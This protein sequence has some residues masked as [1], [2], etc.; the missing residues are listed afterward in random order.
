MSEEQDYCKAT[1]FI[2][3]DSNPLRCVK[4]LNHL[5]QHSNCGVHWEETTRIPVKVEHF[6]IEGSATGSHHLW[7]E[8]TTPDGRKFGKRDYQIINL[9]PEDEKYLSPFTGKEN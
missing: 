7:T 1:Y 9:V 4:P 6:I 5:G 3:D 2:S 8:F